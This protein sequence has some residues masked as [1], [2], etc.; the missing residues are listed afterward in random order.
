VLTMAVGQSD[1]VEPAAAIREAIAQAR[2]QLGGLTPTAGLL[3][4]A[5]ETF[6]P[7]L[8]RTVEAEFPGVQLIGATS[9]AQMSSVAGYL[10]D[11]V[12]LTLFAAEDIDITV[13]LGEHLETDAEAAARAAVDQALARTTREPRLCLLLADPLNG[14]RAMEGVREILPAGVAVVGGASSG[15]N[16]GLPRPSY[17]LLNDRVVEDSVVILLFSGALAYSLSVGTGLRPIGRT[18]TVTRS[19]YGRIV[20]IDGKPATA[21]TAGYVDVAGPATFGNPLAIRK[22]DGSEPYVRVMLTQD[23]DGAIAVPGEIP[24]GSIVQLTTATGDEI[25]AATGDAVRRARESFPDGATPSGALIFS[26]AVRKFLLG[27]RTGQELAEARS[28]LARDL[29]VAGMYCTGEIAPVD[30]DESHFLNE[31]FVTV[32]LGG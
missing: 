2:A 12:A 22:K 18:G 31:S 7:V 28:V 15:P 13:G 30:G 3:F 10:E 27:T 5:F 23:P 20:E 1:D 4:A 26:C 8:A 19:D 29:P 32:L 9:S 25:V 14:Q 6:D 17:Q 16:L 21:F 24:V 11:S